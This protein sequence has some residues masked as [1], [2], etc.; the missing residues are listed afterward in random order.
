MLAEG[1][2]GAGGPE[3]LESPL[4]TAEVPLGFFPCND[5]KTGHVV[6]TACVGVM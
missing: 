6:S 2:G 5:L 1:G 4:T 3:V